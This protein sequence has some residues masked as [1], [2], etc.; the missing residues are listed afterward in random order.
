MT[1]SLAVVINGVETSLTNTT[2]GS[3]IG[4][5][6]WGM[7]IVDN[8]ALRAPGQHGDTWGGFALAPRV[9]SLIFRTPLADL[10][11][12]YTLRAAI[13][14]LF[15]P[16]ALI[17]LKFYTPQGQRCFDCHFYGGGMDWTVVEW[18]AQKYSIQLRASDPTAYDPNLSSW[19][20]QLG[21]AAN[22]AIPSAIPSV[23]GTTVINQSQVISYGGQWLSYP[24]IVIL[25]PITDCVVTNS[26]TGEKLD[27]TGTTIAA[28]DSYTIDCR[29]GFKTVVDSSGTNQIGKLVNSNSLATFHVAASPEV[30]SG[31][32]SINVSGTAITS[33]TQV[34]MTFYN[35]YF[36]I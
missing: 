5:T 29:Y 36:G 18:A 17:T 15:S 7:P 33:V 28:G 22:G 14:T 1:T 27:F 31:I 23:I 8:Y 25:G 3:L 34:S 2:V 20:F 12:M 30:P 11:A 16:S 13:M 9:G 6:G 24:R 10:D 21:G 4:H 19:L 32:N 26:S 35:R